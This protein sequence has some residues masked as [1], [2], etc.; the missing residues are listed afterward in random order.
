MLRKLSCHAD[1]DLDHVARRA[2]RIARKK[3]TA[4]FIDG[5]RTTGCVVLDSDDEIAFFTHR[6]IQTIDDASLH[7]LDSPFLTTGI[8]SAQNM[9]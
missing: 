8:V 9:Q 4:H 7:P 1:G 6:H 3:F 5:V 2:K